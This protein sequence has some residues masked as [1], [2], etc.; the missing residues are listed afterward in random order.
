[1]RGCFAALTIDCTR[2]RRATLRAHDQGLAEEI[3]IS[4]A[5]TNEDAV[6]EFNHI[7]ALGGIQCGLDGGEIAKSIGPD[8]IGRRLGGARA[9][10]EKG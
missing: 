10:Y 7:A 4:I 1:M 3:E 5:L 6:G 2:L 9:N 8:D